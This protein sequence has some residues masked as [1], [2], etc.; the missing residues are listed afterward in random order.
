MWLVVEGWWQLPH[1]DILTLEVSVDYVL[2]M[3]VLQGLCYLQE[4]KGFSTDEHSLR[5]REFLFSLHLTAPRF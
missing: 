5:F 2:A 3:K 4:E 1:Q